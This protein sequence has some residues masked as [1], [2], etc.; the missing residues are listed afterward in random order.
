MWKVIKFTLG[1]GTWTQHTAPRLRPEGISAVR[2][3]DGINEDRN[4]RHMLTS[5]T[6]RT[7]RHYGIDKNSM[8]VEVHANR[9]DLQR[10]WLTFLL[11]I[12]LARCCHV[13]P[14]W[15]QRHPAQ[16]SP[17]G[18]A[19]RLALFS[20]T[21]AEVLPHLN[22]SWSTWSSSSTFCMADWSCNLALILQ[23]VSTSTVNSPKH[24]WHT[25]ADMSKSFSSWY[26]KETEYIF[27]LWILDTS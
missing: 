27:Q 13:L 26:P 15:R 9:H 16:L 18:T 19:T 11:H 4:T 10:Q 3:S 12:V 25:G 8:G 20:A 6:M 5:L 14:R 2:R 24:S 22:Y 21:A 17:C 7:D 1:N 23:L